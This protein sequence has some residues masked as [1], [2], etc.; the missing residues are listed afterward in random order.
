MKRFRPLILAAAIA[1][2]GLLAYGL[3]TLPK[4]Q[5]ADAEGFSSA[6]VAN[7]IKVI[8]RQHHSVAQPAERAA[9]RD[10]LV[11]RL[12][13]LGADTVMLYRYDSLRG[14]QNKHVE[15]V[16][17]AVNVMA[18][19]APAS[20]SEDDTYL[21]L[22]AHYDSRYSQPMPKDTVWSYGAADDGYGLGVILETV[23]QV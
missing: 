10:Y 7:D 18:Q 3:W 11:A 14:P 21:M 17:D 20:S 1:L 22:V 15:Y 16:F 13:Q 5:N 8:S 2:A 23:S 9:V 19:F 4:P 6:R 12:E